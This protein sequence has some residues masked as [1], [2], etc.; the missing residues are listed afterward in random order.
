MAKKRGCE[1]QKLTMH[2]GHYSEEPPEIRSLMGNAKQ[3]VP[4]TS[5]EPLYITVHRSIMRDIESG[6]IVNNGKLITEAEMT[7]RYKVSRATV[8]SALQLL[9]TEGVITT[10]HGSGSYVNYISAAAMRMRL[11]I[12]RGF[13]ELIEDSGHEPSIRNVRLWELELPG[14]ICQ[15]LL[16]A[17]GSQGYALQRSFLGDGIPSFLTTEYIPSS[18]FARL[19]ESTELPDTLYGISGEYFTSPIEYSQTSVTSFCIDEEIA[20]K[21][22]L[23]RGDAVLR[24]Q[25]IHYS[26][27][28]EPL[29]FSDVCVNDRIIQFQVRRRRVS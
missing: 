18:S 11:D 22:S 28:D 4:K 7:E 21:M 17:E 9:E 12:A 5:R 6:A 14:Y 26:A 2:Q 23:K 1:R 20:H 8:R 15:A 29:A 24:L 27:S 25:E 19:P 13:V 3:S 16:L 10:R